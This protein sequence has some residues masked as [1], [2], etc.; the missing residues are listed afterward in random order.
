MNIEISLFSFK[1]K[2][3]LKT[4]QETHTGEKSVRCTECGKTYSRKSVLIK[5]MEE[6]TGVFSK[7]FSCDFCDRI[8]RSSYNMQ[9][10]RR[11]HTGEKP[12]RC[13]VCEYDVTTKSQLDRHLKT[14]SHM[15]KLSERQPHFE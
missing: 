2:Y 13:N 7:I 4:H 10:H 8:F 14:I 1:N 12:Y 3:N 15:N 11:T 5:H 6:H 9:N